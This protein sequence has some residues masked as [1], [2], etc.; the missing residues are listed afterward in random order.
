M[1]P[2]PDGL[3]PCCGSPIYALNVAKNIYDH[4]EQ[5]LSFTDVNDATVLSTTIT[6]GGN[7]IN[8]D[9]SKAS[10]TDKVMAGIGAIIPFVSGSAVKK[11][12]GAIV[13]AVVDAVKGGEKGTDAINVSRKGAF[14]EA[15]R[16]LGIPKSQ[17]PDVNPITGKQYSKVPM[18]DKNGKAVLD[19]NGKPT[20]TREYTF[21]NPDGKKVVVQDH[22]AGHQYP[23]SVGNQGSH[24]NVRPPENIRTGKIP[25]TK[26]HYPFNN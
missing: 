6:R 20:T 13:E 1:K 3:E 22:S 19:N 26:E 4:K 18:T 11:I 15:K 25:G 5:I 12:G 17:N 8:I 2:D 9:G 21:T 10:T 14:N 23:N 7:A 24:F 16:D